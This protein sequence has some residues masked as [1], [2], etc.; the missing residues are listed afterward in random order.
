M[1]FHH[2][3]IVTPQKGVPINDVLKST[4]LSQPLRKQLAQQGISLLMNMVRKCLSDSNQYVV[5]II[6][7]VV[8][9]DSSNC[10]GGIYL[11]PMWYDF[12]YMCPRTQLHQLV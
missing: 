4:A 12:Q 9:V 6:S 5:I 7:V 1:P 2:S 8:S 11:C 10:D 3:M